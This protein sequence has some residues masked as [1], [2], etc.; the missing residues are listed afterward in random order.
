[1]V[2]GTWLAAVKNQLSI[3]AERRRGDRRGGDQSVSDW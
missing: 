3:E 2:S 1:M